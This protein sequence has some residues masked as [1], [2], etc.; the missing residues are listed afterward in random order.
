MSFPRYTVPFSALPSILG[1]TC[2][3]H[4]KACTVPHTCHA[5]PAPSTAC[6]Q[7]SQN[8]CHGVH[9]MPVFTCC[10]LIKYI[11]IQ[12][13]YNALSAYAKK[14]RGMP[15]NQLLLFCHDEEEEAWHT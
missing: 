8:A 7:Y 12:L 6:Q 13:K 14:L 15:R 9:A 1:Y 3:M 5:L 4:A 11:A 2:Y 10:L